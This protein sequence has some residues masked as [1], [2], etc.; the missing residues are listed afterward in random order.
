MKPSH[1]RRERRA[2]RTCRRRFLQQVA[3]GL[4]FSGLGLLA[5]CTSQAIRPQSPDEG[6]S[7]LSQVKLVSDLAVPF[8][9][10][11][12]RIEAIGLVT[13]L[14]GTGSDPPPS[15]QRS[16]LMDEM[17]KR[18][19]AYPNQVLASSDTEM[20]I[21]R[22]YLRPGIQ[23]GD[24]FDVEVRVPSN[25]EAT[26]LR[27]GWLME[28]RLK[29]MAVLN[30]QLHEGR[31]M[32]LS[33]GAILVDPAASGETDRIALT[34]G[35]VL[36]GGI[37]LESRK[38]GLVLKPDHQNVFTSAQVGDAINR[39]FHLFNGGVKQG[40]CKP[41]DDKYLELL[42]HPR[43]K[44]NIERYMLVVRALGVREASAKQ[45]DRLVSLE[46]QL[47]DPVT[48]SQ[49][50]LR[51]EAIGKPA[52]A[53]LH[54]GVAAS[55]TEVRFY[56]AE[57]LAYLDDSDAVEP[58]KE[59]A[60]DEPAF[61]AYALAALSAMDD[62]AAAT[63]LRELIDVPSDE[64]RYGAFRA[65]WAMNP[66]DPFVRGESLGDQFSY[67]VLAT[68]GPPMVHVT[69]SYRPEVLV[70]GHEQR[71]STPALL[72]AGQ[73]I[74]VKAQGPDQVTVSRFS[75][76][77]ADQKRVVSSKIDDI[78]R[79]IADLGGTY[80]DAVQALQQAKAAGVLA[81]RFRVDALPASGRVFDR[82]PEDEPGQDG[83]DEADDRGHVAVT[84]PLPG[85]F[86]ERGI[87]ADPSGGDPDS[88]A[89]DEAPPKRSRARSIF[90]RM[91]GRKT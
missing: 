43:Y 9:M 46:R 22:A 42:V 62:F 72:E 25:S 74:L 6:D 89:S 53:A 19:V 77:E 49:A 33:Q 16:A 70:L 56:A 35:R 78:V 11:P 81:G 4:A 68:S 32:G 14:P 88:D 12:V 8:G 66:A 82:E 52:I 63:A 79:A 73:H 87:K 36:G 71:I 41:K 29:E 54:K 13:G 90:G 50:A 75:H 5:G 80:P 59:L 21:V 47:L 57:A 37:A 44:D 48:A 23:K 20:V 45:L 86:A 3:A 84:N 58:L 83:G 61:R 67:H 18:G 30:S 64:T 2:H 1:G 34:R 65:L 69:R 26:S 55:E 39:R 10:N 51:L 17:Q 27:N 15:P 91:V 31:V 85:L 60:R 24:H 28:S 38:L 7:A 40:V 76:N